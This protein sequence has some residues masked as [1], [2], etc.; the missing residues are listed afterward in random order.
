M[1]SEASVT[2]VASYTFTTN[3]IG[4]IRASGVAIVSVLI[5][6]TVDAPLSSDVA[7][8]RLALALTSP[9]PVPVTLLVEAT[10]R[11]GVFTVWSIQS[12]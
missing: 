1:I 11:A 6:D 2:P 12:R 8:Q 4:W 9:G 5:G 3:R 10:G 7:P